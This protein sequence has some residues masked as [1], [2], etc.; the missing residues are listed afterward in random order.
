M[1]LLIGIAL[2]VVLDL[3]ALRFGRDSR[4]WCLGPSATAHTNLWPVTR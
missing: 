1:A 3:L 2:L 4:D